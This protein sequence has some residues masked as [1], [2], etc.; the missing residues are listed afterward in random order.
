MYCRTWIKSKTETVWGEAYENNL[1]TL[2]SPPGTVFS[3]VVFASYGLAKPND[4]GEWDIDRKAHSEISEE[5]IR[6]VF[7]GKSTGSVWAKND[8][9]GDPIK[10]PTKRLCVCLKYMDNVRYFSRTDFAILSSKVETLSDQLLIL[11]KQL[12]KITNTSKLLEI[13]SNLEKRIEDLERKPTTLPEP[14]APSIVDYHKMYME[15]L[16]KTQELEKTLEELKT[17]DSDPVAYTHSKTKEVIDSMPLEERF[18][19]SLQKRISSDRYGRAINI[20]G[21]SYLAYSDKLNVY[22]NGKQIGR[23]N[24]DYRSCRIEIVK[25]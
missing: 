22:T 5:I 10:G 18:W 23:L 13:I 7:I 17:K 15:Q 25:V 14:T 19:N 21:N 16:L 3:E 2:T 11:Q 9:F 1:L 6:S 8:I 24:Y 4:L 20:N 12:E